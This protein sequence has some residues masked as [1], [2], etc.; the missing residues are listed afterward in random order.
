MEEEEEGG[1]VL[2]EEELVLVGVEVVGARTAARIDRNFHS[3]YDHSQ[4]LAVLEHCH[5]ILSLLAEI[6]R[7]G[8]HLEEAGIAGHRLV[9]DLNI[10]SVHAVVVLLQ[11]AALH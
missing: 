4:S 8:S 6:L 2:L 9:V 11:A 10:R 3:H 7:L 1:L 5:S